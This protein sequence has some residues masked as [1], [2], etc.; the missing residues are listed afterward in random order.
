M[1]DSD[2]HTVHHPHYP[3]SGTRAAARRRLCALEAPCTWAVRLCVAPS[4]MFW[5]DVP[6]HRDVP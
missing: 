4:P 5:Y 1:L 2:G 3:L 6:S